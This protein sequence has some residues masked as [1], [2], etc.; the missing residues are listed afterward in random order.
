MRRRLTWLIIGGLALLLCA[1]CPKER[2]D[3]G[4]EEKM[5]PECSHPSAQCWDDCFRRDAGRYCPSCCT[6]QTILCNDRNPHDFEK[7]KR[8]P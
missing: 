4:P 2:T 5:R 7:C 1:G 3:P 8:E 6:D